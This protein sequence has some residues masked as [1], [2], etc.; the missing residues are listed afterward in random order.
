MGRC[1]LS[2]PGLSGGLGAVERPFAG[3]RFPAPAWLLPQGVIAVPTNGA[4]AVVCGSASGSARRPSDWHSRGQ[5]D[6]GRIVATDAKGSASCGRR[7]TPAGT[8]ASR[9]ALR[10]GRTRKP[11]SGSRFSRVQWSSVRPSVTG[12]L[13]EPIMLRQGRP[14]PRRRG[15]HNVSGDESPG[16]L[17]RAAER[18]APRGPSR[19]GHKESA[20]KRQDRRDN[21]R[22][23]T[24]SEKPK[25]GLRNLQAAEA[26]AAAAAAADLHPA[27]EVGSGLTP[28][29]TQSEPIYRY[30]GSQHIAA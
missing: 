10:Q 28:Q 9:R 29:A 7:M 22:P 8:R 15:L 18:N 17:S 1:A 26:A 4:S 12:S 27:G 21:D 13:L 11:S 3:G 16:Q 5:H 30:R 24:R 20:R 14:D 6:A 19:P 23:P 25:V 2:P